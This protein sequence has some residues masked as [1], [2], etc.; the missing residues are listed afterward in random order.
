MELGG[1]VHIMC[2]DTGYHAD[3]EFKLRSFLGSSDQTNAISGRIKKGKDTI[4]TVD[5][6]WDGKIDIKDKKTG[7]ETSLLDVALLK[8][9]RLPRYLMRLDNQKDYESQTLWLKVSEAILNDDQVAATEQKTIIEE[10]QRARARNLVAPWVPR[11]FHRD[12]H[13]M[14]PDDAALRE[15]TMAIERLSKTVEAMNESQRVATAYRTQN[16]GRIPTATHSWDLFG[17]FVLALVLQALLN[18]IFYHKD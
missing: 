1:K 14:A 2:A 7:E 11:F 3:V 17:G 9:Q 5:G 16:M 6:Y 8:E 4:A 13:V 10:A 18:W 12:L 15:Q